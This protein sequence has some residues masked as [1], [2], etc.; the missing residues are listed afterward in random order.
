MP[1]CGALDTVQ[2]QAGGVPARA[3]G[4]RRP[5]PHRRT[6]P[7]R[8]L[9]RGAVGRPGHPGAGR[10][11][12]PRAAATAR[13]PWV[14]P[15]GRA[16]GAAGAAGRAR[17][18][19]LVRGRHRAGGRPGRQGRVV[20]AARAA[21]APG[22]P[23]P[24]RARPLVFHALGLAEWLF[25]T[26]FCPRCGGSLQPQAS[27]HELVCDSCGRSQFPRTDPAVIMVVAVGRPGQRGR[28][29]PPRPSGDLAR[30]PLLDPGGLLRAGGDPRG[31]RT[32][33]GA[34]GDRRRGG[35][36]RVLRQPALAVAGEPDARL[37]RPRGLGGHQRRQRRD[38]RRPVVHPRRDEGRA[39]RRGSWCSPAASRSAGHSSST[40]TAGR[41]PA[42]G[43]PGGHCAHGGCSR[44]PSAVVAVNPAA[45]AM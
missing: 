4:R 3:H 12:H 18:P 16:R 34:R 6:P 9:A 35:R 8:R 43:E 22:R 20:P 25:V 10:L 29:L 37:R 39:P 21:A 32:P 45:I 38:R 26:R 13:I 27:G 33:R 23:G 17:R 31:R 14:S 28:A 19:G 7:R 1:P 40:G 42:S 15:P 36:R 30:G 24:G 11:R 2:R 44:S 5:R 41:C